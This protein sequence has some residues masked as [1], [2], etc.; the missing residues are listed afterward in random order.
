MSASTSSSNVDNIFHSTDINMSLTHISSNDFQSSSKTSKLV[1]HYDENPESAVSERPVHL[2]ENGR[3]LRTT[4]IN[5][6]AKPRGLI[7]SLGLAIA[8]VSQKPSLVKSSLTRATQPTTVIPKTVS[9]VPSDSTKSCECG[10]TTMLYM[11]MCDHIVC[12]K[13]LEEN[14]T[15]LNGS[16][17]CRHCGIKSDSCTIQRIHPTSIFT[18]VKL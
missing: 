1:K 18:S 10:S 6:Y 11:I 7:Q 16:I 4:K 12:R 9:G 5:D 15:F 2:F 8:Q 17:K 14:Q 3:T 13:C